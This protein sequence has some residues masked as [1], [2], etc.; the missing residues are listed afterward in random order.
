MKNNKK[1]EIKEKNIEVVTNEKDI[2]NDET[3]NIVKKKNE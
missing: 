3:I 1:V 2:E